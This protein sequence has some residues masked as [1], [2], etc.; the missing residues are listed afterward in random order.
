MNKN[1]LRLMTV[2]CVSTI[3]LFGCTTTT[4]HEQTS[5]NETHEHSN[6]V[7]IEIK[8]PVSDQV[9]KELDLE[10]A[11]M[12]GNNPLTDAKVGFE[13]W[14]EGDTTHPYFDAEENK[15][16]HY[17]AK[18]LFEESGEYTVK[19]HVEKGSIHEH[20]EIYITVE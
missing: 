11:V 13:T 14:K 9:N 18:L 2:A 6:E 3:F 4:E 16:G 19:V 5:E 20:K 1:R 8:T 7:S 17:N 10:V 12:D 15:D